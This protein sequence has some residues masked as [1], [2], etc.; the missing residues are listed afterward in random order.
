MKNSSTEN[1]PAIENRVLVS[2]AYFGGLF[3]EISGRLLSD[4][5]ESGII[6]LPAIPVNNKAISYGVP[7]IKT[8]KSALIKSG[9]SKE[10]AEYVQK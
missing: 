8:I 3:K 1:M 6:G 4:Y 7:E 10:D 5:N 2:T 9:K